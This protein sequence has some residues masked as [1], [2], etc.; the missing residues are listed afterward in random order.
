VTVTPASLGRNA[1]DTACFAPFATDAPPFEDRNYVQEEWLAS[2]TDADGEAYKTT[3]LV[4]RPRDPLKFSGVVIV[5]T[6]HVHGIA[7]LWMYCAPYILNAGHGWVVVAAQKTTLDQHVKPSSADRYADLH[8]SGPDTSDFEAFVDLGDPTNTFWSELERRNQATSAI[9]AQVG[10]GLREPDGPFAGYPLRQLILGG[11]SQT[12]SVTSYYIRDAHSQER[13]SDGA[14]V[15]DGYYPSGFP[16]EP[17]PDL[18]VPILQ[19]MSDGDVSLPDYSFRPGHGGRKYRRDDSEVYRLYELAGVAHAMTRAAPYDDVSFWLSTFVFN[20][21]VTLGPKMN[22]LPH[23]ELFSMGLHHL[24]EWV[25]SGEAPPNAARLE[26]GPDGL[27]AKDEH[28]NTLGG[29]RCVQLDVPH[30]SY[31]PNPTNPDGS[32]SYLTVGSEHPFSP[33]QLRRLYGDKATYL[34]RFTTRLDALI[35]AGWLLPENRSEMLREA[36]L[37][38]F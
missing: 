12:G 36:E 32:P 25:T 9:L 29:V 7:P 28:G 16:F 17:F 1:N 2:G 23:G 14:P 3:L 10:A 27:F 11:H 8:I 31:R 24:V 22:T 4:R 21:D 19:V 33:E 6:L 37:V 20:P 38:E 26:L 30:S 15:F 18:D 34:A 35:G 13:R 5:E